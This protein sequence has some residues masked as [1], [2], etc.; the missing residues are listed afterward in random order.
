MLVSASAGW[1]GRELHSS[2]VTPDGTIVLM[3][4]SANG[5]IYKNDTWQ[6]TDKGASWTIVNA[7]SGW[8]TRIRHSSAAMPDGTIV[9][10]GGYATDGGCKNDTWRSTD[11]GATWTG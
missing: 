5:D 1:S 4:G 8:T 6:S 9:L 7:S 3:G 10:M 11:K 2:V